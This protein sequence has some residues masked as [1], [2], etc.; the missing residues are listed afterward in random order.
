[1]EES[2][3]GQDY[4]APGDS[5]RVLDPVCGVAIDPDRAAGKL[6]YAGETFYFCSTDCR[7]RFQEDP[8][9]FIGQ[10]D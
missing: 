10:R 5:D 6:D 7:V 2:W 4:S 1:M 8:G 9:L 3:G